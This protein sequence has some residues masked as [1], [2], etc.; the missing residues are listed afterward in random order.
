MVHRIPTLGAAVAALGLAAWSPVP[1]ISH[2]DDSCCP[3]VHSDARGDVL[4]IWSG[5]RAGMQPQLAERP[6]GGA[7]HSLPDV[8]AAEPDPFTW[9]GDEN[10]SGAAMVLWTRHRTRRSLHRVRASLRE[11]GGGFGAPVSVSPLHY[12]G[13]FPVG[14]MTA[15]GEAIVAW[16][17]RAGGHHQIDVATRA[18]GGSFT[19]PVRV[20]AESREITD[21]P[22]L[23]VNDRGD[24]VLA[25]VRGD[26]IEAAYRPAG[27][28]F[29]APVTVTGSADGS[30][31]SF[32]AAGVDARGDAL[33]AIPTLVRGRSL[34]AA[35]TVVERPAGGSFGAPRTLATLPGD[36]AGLL[37]SLAEAPDGAAAIGWD[38]IANSGTTTYATTRAAGGDFGPPQ[39]LDHGANANGAVPVL[40]FGPDD[41]VTAAWNEERGGLAT[42]FGVS[43][44]VV[45]AASATAGRPFG[46][47]AVVSDLHHDA[48]EPAV[49]VAPDGTATV[50]WRWYLGAGN[51]RIEGATGP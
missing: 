1:V 20:S 43:P 42:G 37:V 46:E 4:A 6:A 36:A 8:A 31:S 7:F 17:A 10:A 45:R 13:N 14:R 32:M 24:A 40:A 5:G 16:L 49:T 21:R 50:L 30:Q 41:R 11:P 44:D 15:S 34:P 3:E 18:P 39:E 12:S 51:G 47:P 28:A 48:I 33:L 27:R 2:D 38:S 19:K 26:R 22:V 9:G 35:L 25:W 23:A 29:G